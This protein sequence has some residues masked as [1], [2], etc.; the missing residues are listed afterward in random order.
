M[1]RDLLSVDILSGNY[2]S[3][4]VLGSTDFPPTV[5]EEEFAGNNSVSENDGEVIKSRQAVCNAKRRQN[6]ENKLR[7]NNERRKKTLIERSSKEGVANGIKIEY[8]KGVLDPNDP[9]L[10]GTIHDYLARDGYTVVGPTIEGLEF[11]KTKEVQEKMNSKLSDC[12]QS[13]YGFYDEAR[14]I[15]YLDKDDNWILEMCGWLEPWLDKGGTFGKEISLMKVCQTARVQA[16][17]MDSEP[18][19]DRSIWKT[20]KRGW[21]RDQLRD[22]E[23]IFP[24]EILVAL[25]DNCVTRVCPG[26]QWVSVMTDAEFNEYLPF[27]RGE[28]I[29]LRK[30]EVLIFHPNLVH[31]GTNA[32][33]NGFDIKV[34][35]KIIE[36]RGQQEANWLPVHWDANTTYFIERYLSAERFRPF[37][38]M[39]AYEPQSIFEGKPAGELQIIAEFLSIKRVQQELNDFI[40]KRAKKT[41]K[42]KIHSK[43]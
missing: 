8:Y 16:L 27:V 22:A 42:M 14:R 15:E 18:M 25:N 34:H 36:S 23:L 17:H 37:S 43:G 21:T 2:S 10:F 9:D 7:E 39:K 41:K 38:K 4:S 19:K 1:E 33:Y 35:G 3:G 12:I 40:A 13:S 5:F 26:S 24:V 20:D 30:G 28:F 6:E 32:M 31:S 29:K 11:I